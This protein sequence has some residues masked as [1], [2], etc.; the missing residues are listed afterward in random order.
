LKIIPLSKLRNAF[1][2]RK[3]LRR[4]KK[5]I[6]LEK[7]VIIFND[8]LFISTIHSLKILGDLFNILILTHYKS[9]NRKLSRDYIIWFAEN[10]DQ[11]HF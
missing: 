6:N 1:L 5:K 10:H 2:W 8:D 3:Y 4:I 9:N 7:M 11:N